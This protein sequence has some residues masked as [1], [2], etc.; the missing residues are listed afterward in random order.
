MPT[1]PPEKTTRLCLAIDQGTH[2]SRALVIDDAG[3]IHRT[4]TQ[5]IALN[6]ID[7]HRVEQDPR[8]IIASTENVIR[9]AAAG[10]VIDR[11]ALATQRSTVVAWDDTGPLAPALSWQDTRAADVLERI[12]LDYLTEAT[13]LVPSPHYAASKIRWLLDH[14]PAVRRARREGKLTIGPLAAYLL[15]RLAGRAGGRPTIDHANAARTTLFNIHTRDWDPRL[16]DT[17]GIPREVLPD[18]V[19]VRG[20]HGAARTR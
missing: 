2:A 7:D 3:C 10:L 11:I 12:D 20:D 14:H 17:F 19:P 6:R 1:S 8:E 5:E 18:C 16:L 9:Q 4:C 15:D 13:G